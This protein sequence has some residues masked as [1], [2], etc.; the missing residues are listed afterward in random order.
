MIKSEIHGWSYY[1]IF[2]TVI[3]SQTNKPVHLCDARTK[4]Y[5]NFNNNQFKFEANKIT[6]DKKYIEW[7][8]S[9]KQGDSGKN[10]RGQ[11]VRVISHNRTLLETK[12]LPGC[13][14]AIA[15]QIMANYYSE[16][17]IRKP[18][19]CPVCCLLLYLFLFYESRKSHLQHVTLFSSWGYFDSDLCPEI[20][21]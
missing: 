3:Y 16:Q 8:A 14:A 21:M 13:T 5:H 15:W 2:H 12:P 6:K 18:L 11:N 10:G 1:D 7:L 17:E 19:A 4:I 9:L 20:K